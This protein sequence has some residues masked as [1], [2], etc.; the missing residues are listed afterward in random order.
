MKKKKKIQGKSHSIR[1]RHVSITLIKKIRNPLES[2]SREPDYHQNLHGTDNASGIFFAT[3][4]ELGSVCAF[5][6]GVGT[7]LNYP[8][9]SGNRKT[10]IGYIRRFGSA[11]HR[12]SNRHPTVSPISPRNHGYECMWNIRS[13]KK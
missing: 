9:I 8:F 10:W 11:G 6:R 5:R 1:D 2:R 13:S 3:V 7:R 12:Y 4:V